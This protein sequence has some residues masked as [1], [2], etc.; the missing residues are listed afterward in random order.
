MN[1]SGLHTEPTTQERPIYGSSRLGILNK[2][3]VFNLNGS[4]VSKSNSTIGIKEYEL[5]DHLG[6]VS[7]VVLDRKNSLSTNIQPVIISNSDYYPFGYPIRFRTHS[8]GYRYGFNGQEGDGEIYGDKLNYAFQYRMYDA[9]IGRFWSVDPLKSDYPWNSTYA[10]AENR[11]IDGIDLEGQE[12]KSQHKWSDKVT[13]PSHIKNI[14][15]KGIKNVKT[16]TYQQVYEMSISRLMKP[17]VLNGLQE[18][19]ANFAFYPLIDFASYYKL[20]IF[21]KSYRAD[22]PEKYKIIDND[23][24]QFKTTDDLKK[25]LGILYAAKDFYDDKNLFLIGVDFDKL[26]KSDLL[27][28]QYRAGLFSEETERIYHVS[29]IVLVEAKKISVVQG[30]GDEDST[31]KIAGKSYERNSDMSA[32]LQGI[33][34]ITVKGEKAKRWNFNLFDKNK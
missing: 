31:S 13:D 30:S 25:M 12:W 21:I 19:C 20:P 10:F 8:T 23:L 32:D 14:E 2:Q 15:A 17:Y 24:M 9:R 7:V 18:D 4:L 28:F 33:A 26:Q 22:T 6:N 1:L 29:T 3:V 34:N 16:L 27:L 5:S 11:V